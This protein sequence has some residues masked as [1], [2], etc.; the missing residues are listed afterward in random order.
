MTELPLAPKRFWLQTKFWQVT[1]IISGIL[2]FF[3]PVFNY[4]LLVISGIEFLIFFLAAFMAWR[5]SQIDNRAFTA[6]TELPHASRRFRLKTKFWQVTAIISGILAFG[7]TWTYASDPASND[8]LRVITGIELLI[9]FL[10][11][12][13]AWRL[14]QIDNREFRQFNALHVKPAELQGQSAAPIDERALT[15]LQQKTSYWLLTTI[16]SG[17]LA[18]AGNLVPKNWSSDWLTVPSIAFFVFIPSLVITFRLNH[19][20]GLVAR[21]LEALHSRSNELQR[22]TTELNQPPVEPN[23][24]PL[25]PNQPPLE[26]NQPPLELNQPPVELN[27]PPPELSQAPLEL[28]QPPV[29]YLRSFNADQLTA[30]LEGSFTEEEHLTHV[31]MHIG[32]VVAVGRPGEELPEAGARRLYV[33]DNEWQSTVEGL[34]KRAR[35]VVIRTGLSGGLRWEFHKCLELLRPEQLLLVV[36]SEA[37]LNK[38]LAEIGGPSQTKTGFQH[39]GQ[40]SIGSLRAFVVFRENWK[41]FVLRLRSSRFWY[42]AQVG[43][44][45]IQPRLAYSL[46]PLFKQLGAPWPRP[47]IE[48]IHITF[49]VTMIAMTAC[50]IFGAPN[51]VLLAIVILTG[52]ATLAASVLFAFRQKRKSSPLESAPASAH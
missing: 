28:S 36:D 41:P 17:I 11:T 19:A 10:A 20:K 26:P 48:P 23:Q 40:R 30:K 5:L 3:T 4:Y 51:S 16:I 39:I 22:Q 38:M 42:T 43:S 35:L 44:S 7:S 37:E 32:P 25:E 52:L 24:P 9:F 13:M 6:M 46:R 2:A 18:F 27:Q 47:A 34:I 33:G 49:F 21:R 8:D 14:S 50:E 1:T 15:R 12:F 29:I 45:Y 31:L